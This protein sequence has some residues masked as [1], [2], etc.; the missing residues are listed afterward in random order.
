M[1]ER[2]KKLATEKAASKDQP[3]TLTRQ[4][5]RQV[6]GIDSSSDIKF[7]KMLAEQALQ[8]Q[9]INIQFAKRGSANAR[10][11]PRDSQTEV[12]EEGLFIPLEELE[13]VEIFAGNLVKVKYKKPH[14]VARKEKTFDKPGTLIIEKTEDRFIPSPTEDQENYLEEESSEEEEMLDA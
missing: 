5:V 14:T 7:Y 9:G 12:T 8:K 11:N 10:K 4:A 2:L 6:T 1:I 3:V 13:K